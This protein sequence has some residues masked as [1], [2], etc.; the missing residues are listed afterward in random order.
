MP[1]N[2]SGDFTRIYSWV[3]DKAAGIKITASRMDADT[4]DIVTVG[5]GNALTRDGQGMPEAN[6]SMAGFR[7]TGASSAVGTGDYVT[8]GQLA[9]STGSVT[10]V[11]AANGLF[12]NATVSSTL[13]AT[14]VTATTGAFNATVSGV[15]GAFTGSV[16]ALDMTAV[17]TIT[18]VNGDVSALNGTVAGKNGAFN[19]TVS[20]VTGAFTGSVTAKDV[21][22]SNDVSA[23][24]GTVA[25]LNGA[26]NATVSGVTGAFTGSVTGLDGAF[27]NSLTSPDGISGDQVVNASQFQGAFANP[28]VMAVGPNWRVAFGSTVLATN[29]SGD[30][31]ISFGTTFATAC[32]TVLA[33]N[34]DA[35]ASATQ[36]NIIGFTG[37]DFSFNC[38]TAISTTVRI[39]W[40]AIGY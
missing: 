9:G 29:G 6:L 34:G 1:W 4:N 23:L 17:N 14:T 2:G 32:G 25:A 30:A 31:T 38:P 28:G 36:V 10:T 5:L 11:S 19:A 40:M 33:M 37:T 20:G 18:S 8:L 7:H 13:V 39:N 24:N 22:V 26:F 35:V 12:T 21:I 3:D 27:A 15:T 16:T